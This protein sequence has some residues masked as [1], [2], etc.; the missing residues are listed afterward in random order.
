MSKKQ[1]RSEL[2]FAFVL[3]AM[4]V[5]IWLAIERFWPRWGAIM[6]LGTPIAYWVFLHL[7]DSIVEEARAPYYKSRRERLSNYSV[8]VLMVMWIWLAIGP[9]AAS[10]GFLMLMAAP[11]MFFA[12]LFLSGWIFDRDK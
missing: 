8:I 5:W 12:F 3:I 11:A 9:W 1:S 7:F 6:L 4:A 10:W 2:R